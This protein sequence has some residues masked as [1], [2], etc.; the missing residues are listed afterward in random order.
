MG[1][2]VKNQH[3]DLICTSKES[4]GCCGELRMTRDLLLDIEGAAQDALAATLKGDSVALFLERIYDRVTYLLDDLGSSTSDTTS[5][6]STTPSA[7]ET[8]SDEDFAT[9]RMDC[10]DTQ[11]ASAE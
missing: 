8:T 7:I 11:S 4:S 1:A 3:A 5:N 10:V 6:V 9:G 2:K